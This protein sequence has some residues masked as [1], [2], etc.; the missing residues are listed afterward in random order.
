VFVEKPLAVNE[1]QLAEI[2]A[3]YGGHDGPLLMTGFNRRFSPA[4]VR[5]RELLA[6]RTTPLVADYRVNAGYIPLDHWVHGR[7]GGG[8]NIGEACHMYDVF[9]VL[10]GP[11]EVVSVTARA[12]RPDGRRLL[13][14]DN[15]AAVVSYADGSVCTLTYTALGHRDHA[16]ERMEVFADG[17]VITL[18]DYKSLTTTA[19]GGWHGKTQQKGHLQELDALASAITGGGVWPISLEDQLRA[20]RVAFA[21]ETQIHDTR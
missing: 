19:G 16:K 15:F 20:M 5:A 10:V 7:E 4:I 2:E 17:A 21:V 18:D 3:F 11:A 9:D 1:E 12:I 13:S 8:R 6:P 14:S